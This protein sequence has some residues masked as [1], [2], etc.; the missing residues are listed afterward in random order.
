MNLHLPES[1]RVFFF[2]GI[3]IRTSATCQKHMYTE[4]HKELK[5]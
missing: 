4:K 3:V 2:A 5:N 1:D